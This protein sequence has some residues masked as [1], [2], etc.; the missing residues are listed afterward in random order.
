MNFENC[1]TP[2]LRDEYKKLR[3]NTIKTLGPLFTNKD[4][5]IT[6][7]DRVEGLG[8]EKTPQNIVLCARDIEENT[9]NCNEEREEQAIY[10]ND[11]D[12]WEA[13]QEAKYDL[14]KEA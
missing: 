12:Q 6:V 9:I 11:R 3:S 4:F 1:D 2:M 14:M 13:S 7:M 8:L 10:D 5:D